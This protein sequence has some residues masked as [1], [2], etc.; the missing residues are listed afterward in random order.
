ME[1]ADWINDQVRDE[2]ETLRRTP[3]LIRRSKASILPPPVDQFYTS[4]VRYG[5]VHLGTPISESA[6]LC[7]FISLSAH[8]CEPS[9]LTL[10][11]GGQGFECPRLHSIKV[12]ICR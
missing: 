12:P 11:G 1:R 10:H 3:L 6:C 7:W 9:D 4:A 5:G 8:L 2:I